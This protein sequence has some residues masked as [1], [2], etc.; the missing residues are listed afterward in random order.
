MHCIS[1][2]DQKETA[3]HYQ[4]RTSIEG[5]LSIPRLNV[6]AIGFRIGVIGLDGAMFDE[7]G[8]I[9]SKQP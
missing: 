3:K 2:W 4:H 7:L 6:F 9:V 1:I 8:E 5:S